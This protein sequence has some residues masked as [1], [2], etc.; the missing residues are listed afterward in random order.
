MRKI[1]NKIS[2]CCGGVYYDTPFGRMMWRSEQLLSTLSDPQW[3]GIGCEFIQNLRASE[4]REKG[5]NLGKNLP[6]VFRS[7]N[8]NSLRS[9]I[10][11]ILY[12]T[13]E[14]RSVQGVTMS[15]V[16][17]GDHAMAYANAAIIH[18]SP[19]N[20]NASYCVM[21]PETFLT[22]IDL[23]ERNAYAKQGWLA[24]LAAEKEPEFYVQT[25]D[26]AVTA[27][28]FKDMRAK[29]G[30]DLEAAL[31]EAARESLKK[32]K[33]GA[34]TYANHYHLLALESY[35]ARLRY[36][37]KAGIQPFFVKMDPQDL[38]DIGQTFGPNIFAGRDEFLRLPDLSVQA[39]AHLTRI[40]AEW[41]LDQRAP[42]PFGQLLDLRGDSRAGFL[43]MSKT[44]GARRKAFAPEAPRSLAA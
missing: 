3:P 32:W 11:R 41:G 14:P 25:E 36:L 9:F 39:S 10:P 29:H 16:H 17:E 43:H 2:G 18:T 35:E 5:K 21:C 23:T 8:P 42:M 27:Q 30:G 28:E 40:K 26:D 19:F 44:W 20:T 6:A 33:A 4:C 7:F 12:N 1:Y 31:L 37:R 24:S 15:R 34:G 22:L 13:H 38:A